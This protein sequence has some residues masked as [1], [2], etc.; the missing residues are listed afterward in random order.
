MFTEHTLWPALTR[1]CRNWHIDVCFL[2]RGDHEGLRSWECL[3]LRKLFVA[4]SLS[5]TGLQPLSQNCIP[6]PFSPFPSPFY[7]NPGQSDGMLGLRALLEALP[8]LL[9]TVATS[10]TSVSRAFRVMKPLKNT[11][12]PIS[13]NVHPYLRICWNRPSN[14]G[15]LTCGYPQII[16][17]NRICPY[18]PFILGTPI[19]GNSQIGEKIADSSGSPWPCGFASPPA[20]TWTA[21]I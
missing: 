6:F 18:K 19:L 5:S 16:H 3:A 10:S 11:S 1:S 9:S 20:G 12:N 14:G 15:F 21:T 4:N 2:V 17:F 13:V 7:I 8:S